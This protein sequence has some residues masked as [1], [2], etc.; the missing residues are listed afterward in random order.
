LLE[1]ENSFI[2]A[3][4]VPFVHFI[5][6]STQNELAFSIKFFLATPIAHGASVTPPAPFATVDIRQEPYGR[7]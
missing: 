5:P 2:L 3:Y 4:F 7:V 1:E 6:F